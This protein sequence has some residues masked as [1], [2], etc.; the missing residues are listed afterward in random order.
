MVQGLLHEVQTRLG[1]L[2]GGCDDIKHHKWFRGFDF[3]GMM[4]RKLR[5][6]W[7]PKIRNN[8]DTSHFDAY[9][10]SIQSPEALPNV[11]HG[12]WEKQFNLEKWTFSV[13][14]TT[15]AAAAG[16]TSRGNSKHQTDY[17][18]LKQQTH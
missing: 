4:G 9:E 7:V 16:P 10:E 6:P 3:D 2:R 5:A 11:D 12:E 8:T 14:Q 13:I 1:N 15:T 17:L 18:P